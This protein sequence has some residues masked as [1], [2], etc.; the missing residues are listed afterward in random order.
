MDKANL[1]EF[2]LWAVRLRKCYRVDGE[3]MSPLIKSGDRV[4][5]KKEKEYRKGDIVVS[6]HP[7]K[8]NLVLI[9]Q[10]DIISEAGISLRGMNPESTDSRSLG[11]IPQNYVLGKVTSVM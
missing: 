6:K 3:S 7:F 11:K 1:K 10:I 2:I 8:R 9:K 5:A 4:F